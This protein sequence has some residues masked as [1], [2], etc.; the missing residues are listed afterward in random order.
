MTWH[1][2]LWHNLSLRQRFM[3]AVGLGVSLLVALVV[4]VIARYEEQAME[5]QLHHLSVNEMT[6]LHALIVNVMAKRPEDPDNIGVT[7]FNNWF[8]SRNAHYAG[9][10]WSVWGPKVSAYMQDT[11]PAR[12]QKAAQ[13]NVDREALTSGQPVGRFVGDSY[14]YSMPIVLGVTEGAAAEVCHTC[15][16]GMGMKDGEVIAVLS[17]SLSV[18]QERRQLMDVITSLIVGGLAAAIAAVLGVRW[19]LG[20]VITRPIGAMIGVMERLADGDTSVEVGFIDR[21]DEVGDIART[22]QV[23]KVHMLETDRLRD[24]QERERQQASR[25]KAAALQSMADEFD[26]TVKVKVAGVEAATTG[27]RTSAQSMAARSEHSGSRSVDVGGASKITT[28]RSNAAAEATRQLAQSVNSVA[29]QVNQSTQIARQA[30]DDVST[31]AQRMVELSQ[32]VQA[33]GE[34]V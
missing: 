4:V 20:K 21:R 29:R 1:G 19:I 23:F 8:G 15:H 16:E 22:V 3:I 6:S 13:D 25:D 18:E 26:R 10:V 28:E 5:R 12:A 27:I 7:V 24:A 2:S 9:K 31:T 30:V 33:I 34:V 32:A 14:R 17:S 11:D